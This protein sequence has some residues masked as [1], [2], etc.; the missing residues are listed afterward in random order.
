MA[1]AFLAAIAPFAGAPAQE[2]IA[3]AGRNVE[4]HFHPGALAPQTARN[5]A[6]AAWAAVQETLPLLEKWRLLPS[7]AVHLDVWADD[8]AFR[9]QM[10]RA[11]WR[12][13]VHDFA[14]Q[15]APRA[16]VALWPQFSPA[17][18]RV[19]GLPPD[20]RD[21]IVR[22]LAWLAAAQTDVGGADPWLCHVVAAGAL[23]LL[24]NPELASGVDVRFDGR[25]S[26]YRWASL[27]G[28]RFDLAR[29]VDDDDPPDTADDHDR[30]LEA[31][32]WLAQ[33]MAAK[34]A[35]YWPSR[36]LRAS[37]AARRGQDRVALRRA[38]IMSVL[39]RDWKKIERQIGELVD[40]ASQRWAV[41]TPTAARR[42]DRILLA[43]TSAASARIL[44]S[45]GIPKGPFA[46]RGELELAAPADPELRI[47]FM[48][49]ERV[50]GVLIC[51]RSCV[52]AMWEDGRWND[53]EVREVGEDRYGKATFSIE[54]RNRITVSLNG[55][56]VLQAPYLAFPLRD[57]IG[58]TCNDAAV[59]LR[60]L[61][62]EALDD[63]R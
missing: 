4:L 11:G 42:G 24:D 5:L 30:S 27:Q 57:M 35:T 50:L 56:Q 45:E 3:F 43:G 63:G 36:L 29:H 59:W 55:E 26:R 16:H 18:L 39:G 19:V 20:T 60:D 53:I 8:A 14:E 37:G 23:D 54:V 52:L 28:R 1:A 49:E 10:Q 6:D 61:R 21:G 17:V 34:N 62:I 9:Q 47:G 13:E 22:Q 7:T 51:K 40:G 46:I 58:F 41:V 12:F 15:V 25:R 32:G 48:E 38:Q 2:P 44:C 33:A 31:A